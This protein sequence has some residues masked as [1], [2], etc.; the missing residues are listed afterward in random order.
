MIDT[1]QTVHQHLIDSTTT[2]E[3]RII[4]D[5]LRLPSNQSLDL[6]SKIDTFYNNAWTKLIV[7]VTILF[8]IVGIVIPL[9]IQYYQKRELKLGEEKLKAEIESIE[10]RLKS[11]IKQETESTLEILTKKINMLEVEINAKVSARTN[12][13]Q[14]MIEVGKNNFTRATYLYA[15]S[16]KSL[17]QNNEIGNALVSLYEIGL[18]VKKSN[19]KELDEMFANKGY[20]FTSFLD[21]IKLLSVTSDEITIYLNDIR[22]SYMNLIDE[23]N[24]NNS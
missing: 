19:K 20:T 21:A 11:E 12:H 17:L 14:A 9:I 7:T 15:L 24:Q 2:L 16:A 5:T 23:V 1:L 6:I 4:L 18:T 13:L 10:I 3:T 22:A 8:T